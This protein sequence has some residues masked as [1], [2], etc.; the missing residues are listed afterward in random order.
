MPDFM[1]SRLLLIG[2][3]ILIFSELIL[4][5]MSDSQEVVLMV[6]QE[7]STQ[8]FLIPCDTFK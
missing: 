1:K 5:Y 4:F 8:W 3:Q 7:V 6:A 2:I